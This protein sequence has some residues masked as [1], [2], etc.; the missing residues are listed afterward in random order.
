MFTTRSFTPQ[1]QRVLSLYRQILKLGNSW[2][3]LS[4]HHTITA[5]HKKIYEAQF[6]SKEKDHFD[7]S[8]DESEIQREKEYIL[9]EAKKA[10]RVNKDLTNP[11]EIEDKINEAEKRL[12]LTQHY[13]IPY[14]R[15]EHVNLYDTYWKGSLD[16]NA[17]EEVASK[18]DGE[19]IVY[20]N[21]NNPNEVHDWHSLNPTIPKIERKRPARHSSSSNSTSDSSSSNNSST[22]KTTTTT[23]S[24]NTNTTPQNTF[25]RASDAHIT[26]RVAAGGDTEF[27][28]E[29]ENWK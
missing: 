27:N 24:T 23:P 11:E 9:S 26:S 7:F 25:Q 12:F 4:N 10:F 3:K 22:S 14:E 5:F 15:P 21:V 17:A 29:E 28:L 18:D 8:K 16:E 6:I 20:T 19:Q 13:G 2:D 1:Q